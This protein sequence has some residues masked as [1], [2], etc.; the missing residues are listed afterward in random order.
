MNLIVVVSVLSIFTYLLI[1]DLLYLVTVF[2]PPIILLP[3][4]RKAESKQVHEAW[5]DMC[6]R[7]PVLKKMQLGIATSIK[8]TLDYD[9]Y[10]KSIRSRAL[11]GVLKFD[12]VLGMNK[13]IS[14]NFFTMQDY[15]DCTVHE[16]TH[17]LTKI[18]IPSFREHQKCNR[19]SYQRRA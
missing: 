1:C 11:F 18:L 15:Y 4:L 10:G 16:L 19:Y 6:L 9:H 17:T 14:G 5:K 8:V 12:A 2:T 3:G 7:Y 13:G